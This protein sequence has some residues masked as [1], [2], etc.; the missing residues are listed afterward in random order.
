MRSHIIVAVFAGFA[1]AALLLIVTAFTNVQP[2]QTQSVVRAQLIELVDKN[3]KV[4]ASLKIEEEEET[5]FRIMDSSGT[6]R[7]KIGGGQDGSGIVLLN[8][9]TNPGVHI[10]AKGI[11]TSLTLVSKDGKKNEIVP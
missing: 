10:L 3:G 2:E 4:R 1:G 7:V 8:E 9:E 5:V 6:I 11:K